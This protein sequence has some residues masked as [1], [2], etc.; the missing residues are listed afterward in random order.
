MFLRKIEWTFI[1]YTSK[2][3]IYIYI[4]TLYIN[5]D[6]EKNLNRAHDSYYYYL[7]YTYMQYDKCVYLSV[8]TEIPLS[9]TNSMLSRCFFH[10]ID[11]VQPL[12][13]D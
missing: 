4:L 1:K 9:E 12:K 11:L 13:G 3:S 10:W 5:N 2:Y 6:R 8:L 7:Y